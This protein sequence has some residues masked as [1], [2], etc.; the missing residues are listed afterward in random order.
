MKKEFNEDH[1]P[2][3]YLITFRTYGTWLH[4]DNRGSV[5]RHHNRF[6]APLIPPNEKWLRSNHLLLKQEPVILS[7]EQRA[8]IKKSIRQTCE[9]R[10]W[11]VYKTNVRTNHLHTVVS[12]ACGPSR[13]LNALKSNATRELREAGLWSHPSS[14]WADRG[15]K[16]YL[17][18][19][20]HLTKAIEYVELDQG[21][22]LPVLDEVG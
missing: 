7:N 16:R 22:K 8:L 19:E 1:T 14:P 5:D 11:R 12:A 2:L 13:I 15:S 21:D 17:W 18:T 10:G 6:G 4:G 20:E 9:I 3:G